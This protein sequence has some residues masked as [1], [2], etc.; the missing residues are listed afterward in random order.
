M[1][2]RPVSDDR[3]VPGIDGP[4]EPPAMFEELVQDDTGRVLGWVLRFDEDGNTYA[5]FGN[6]RLGAFGDDATAR[7]FVE[8]ARRGFQPPG[9]AL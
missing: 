8:Q 4:D 6:V 2:W 7:E 9:S 5:Y 3:G 1:T